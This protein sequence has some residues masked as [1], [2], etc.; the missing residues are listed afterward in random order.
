MCG[1]IPSAANLVLLK[2]EPFSYLAIGDSDIL[3]FTRRLD[4]VDDVAEKLTW[5]LDSPVVV[6]SI[7][8]QIFSSRS[9]L[10]LVGELKK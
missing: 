6:L 3:N 9:N 10:P 7:F 2:R 1:P 8:G 4:G 5:P